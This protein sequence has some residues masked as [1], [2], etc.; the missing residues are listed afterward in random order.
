M[1][2]PR[3]PLSS[4]SV[5]RWAE[6]LRL[7]RKLERIVE[8]NVYLDDESRVGRRRRVAGFL[9]DYTAV[10]A[11]DRLDDLAA[12]MDEVSTRLTVEAATMYLRRRVRRYGE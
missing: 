4:S 12:T 11:Q 5:A 7:L 6:T 1:P 2:P 3:P 9:A 10:D 8:I